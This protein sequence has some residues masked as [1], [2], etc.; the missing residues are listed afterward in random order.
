MLSSPI[1]VIETAA[2]TAAGR[3]KTVVPGVV[4]LH[5]SAAVCTVRPENHRGVGDATRMPARQMDHGCRDHTV[6]RCAEV[7]GCAAL[8]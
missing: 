5:S 3:N 8:Y 1:A 4:V 2:E 6:S 7:S